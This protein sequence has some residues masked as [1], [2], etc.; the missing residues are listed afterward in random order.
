MTIARILCLIFAGAALLASIANADQSGS[1]N[2]SAPSQGS[3]E[4]VGGHPHANAD[5]AKSGGRK[6][7]TGKHATR[8]AQPSHNEAVQGQTHGSSET[9]SPNPTA[10]VSNDRALASPGSPA[11]PAQTSIGRGVH[12]AHAATTPNATVSSALPVRPP[13]I[14]SGSATSSS[15]P[16]HLSP[17]PPVINGATGS[18]AHNSAALSGTGMHHTP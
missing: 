4:A 6:A 7:R 12:A 8:K 2:S 10:S 17:N 11:S 5:A 18:K 14:T 15:N 9:K 3:S 13:A 16:R 1:Q